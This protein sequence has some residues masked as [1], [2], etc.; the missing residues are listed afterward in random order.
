MLSK[1]LDSFDWGTEAVW[2]GSKTGLYLV[3][4]RSMKK[5]KKGK[6]LNVHYNQ[7]FFY[8]QAHSLIF[9]VYFEKVRPGEVCLSLN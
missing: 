5:R 2:Y 3:A 7:T 6:G 9:A 4:N 1:P 8:S